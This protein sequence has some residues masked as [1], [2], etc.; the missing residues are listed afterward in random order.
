MDDPSGSSK[1]NKRAFGGVQGFLGGLVPGQS[2]TEYPEGTGKILRAGSW[3]KF[4]LHYTPN[5]KAVEDQIFSSKI[6]R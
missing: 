5:G 1:L 4:Q 2:L 3:L 6:F